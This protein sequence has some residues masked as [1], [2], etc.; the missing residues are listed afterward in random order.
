MESFSY[1]MINVCGQNRKIRKEGR[2]WNAEEKGD[3]Y[4]N[5]TLSKELLMLGHYIQKVCKA[6]NL[7]ISIKIVV[8]L[9]VTE[10]LL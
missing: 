4:G 1:R 6:C 3:F 10:N 9:Y 7:C 8:L 5:E 2:Y